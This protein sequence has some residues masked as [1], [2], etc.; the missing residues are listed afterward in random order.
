MY[1]EILTKPFGNKIPHKDIIFLTVSK[2]EAIKIIN[3]LTN[4]MIANTPNAGRLETLIS[5]NSEEDPY[6]FSIGVE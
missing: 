1:M 2:E 5:V 4:Q 6:Y 3:S